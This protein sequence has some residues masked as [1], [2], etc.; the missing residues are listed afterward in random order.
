[1][2]FEELYP[3]AFNT[4]ASSNP[5]EVLSGSPENLLSAANS[6]GVHHNPR[7]QPGGIGPVDISNLYSDAKFKSNKILQMMKVNAK[8]T[9]RG[10]PGTQ[11]I[12]PMNIDITTVEILT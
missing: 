5:T 8:N 3:D 2:R 6:G 7:E 10:I 4:D 11:T 1:M 12:L 9:L